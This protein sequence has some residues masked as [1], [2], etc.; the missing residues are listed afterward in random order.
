MSLESGSQ[1][2]QS[3]PRRESN[4]DAIDWVAVAAP[5]T[6]GVMGAGTAGYLAALAVKRRYPSIDV[7]I[8]QSSSEPIIGVGE[9]TTTLMPPFLHAQLDLGVVE[10]F[11]AVRPTFKLGIKFKWGPP[12]S[13]NYPFGDAHPVAA[14]QFDGDLATQS[15]LSLLMTEDRAPLLR[16]PG[17]E[18]AS[19]L[20]RVK[21]AYHLDNVPFV[22]FL[23]QAAARA[24][25]GNVDMKIDA[26]TLRGDGGVDAVRSS[27]GRELRFDFYVDAT[28]FRS[29]LV[30]QTL[31]SPFQ[32]YASSLFC[33]RAV[34]ATLPQ[35]DTIEPYT[36]AETM[37][38]GWCW[39]IPVR[40]EDHRGYVYSSAFLSDDLAVEE[41]RAAN[42][43]MAEPWF[44]R[45]RSGRHRE[46][47]IKN[48]F[49]L[50]NA[51]AFVEPLES[52]A[53]HMVI[54][55]IAYLLDGIER[56]NDTSFVDH[57]NA[58]VGAQWDYLRWFLAIHYK[59]N[60]RLDTAFWR[61]ARAGVDVSGLS[62]ILERFQR[63]GP[64]PMD[65]GCAYDPGNPAA[66]FN[67]IMPL[68]LGQE[69][70]APPGQPGFTR[71]EWASR[72]ADCRRTARYALPQ[73]EA[74]EILQQQP[75]L[76][77][78]LVEDPRSWCRRPEE[79]PRV[80]F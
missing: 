49:A 16:G 12:G 75:D 34:V 17:G 21:F 59:F 32:S 47:W 74:L 51:Y 6:I 52:T 8:V 40:G 61:A 22:R 18:L 27:D 25:I 26:V 10:L 70:P 64:W 71:P 55:G 73:R 78:E 80:S 56:M 48:V 7:T 30:G 4:P 9:A 11:E 29:L 37:N 41:M 42:P 45:F 13:F 19:L 57:A 79:L 46:M 43:G 58:A 14:I 77:R 72:V 39:R 68:L 20:S 60:R 24:G 54:V 31:G 69:V 76:L 15:L 3:T 23:E 33:D 66:G 5:R 53:L 38:A 36:T 1:A 2:R 63:E 35:T 28:G 50:G 65:T 62:P 44:V 67:G